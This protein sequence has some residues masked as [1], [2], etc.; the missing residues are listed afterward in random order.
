MNT[1][2]NNKKE[3]RI[4][5]PLSCTHV[6]CVSRDRARTGEEQIKLQ[7]GYISKTKM[8]EIV[9]E[10]AF[11]PYN[12]SYMTYHLFPAHVLVTWRDFKLV[13]VTHVHC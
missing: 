6:I 8:A 9:L 11:Y 13:M 12:D 2:E 5:P 10:P 1:D 4:S 3:R 7:L